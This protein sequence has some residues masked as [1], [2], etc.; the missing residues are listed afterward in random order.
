MTSPGHWR[1]GVYQRLISFHG[2]DFFP[3]NHEQRVVAQIEQCFCV[4][5]QIVFSHDHCMFLVLCCALHRWIITVC[6]LY[7]ELVN[8]ERI[9]IDTLVVNITSECQPT[10]Q[11]LNG[12][13]LTLALVVFATRDYSFA[14]LTRT[15]QLPTPYAYVAPI[16]MPPSRNLT[17]REHCTLG[18]P[19]P[20]TIYQWCT[21]DHCSTA[22]CLSTRSVVHSSI[23]WQP[24]CLYPVS[25]ADGEL[26]NL[27]TS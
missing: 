25:H 17:S 18:H 11:L 20:T 2:V 19:W 9:G 5:F 26:T 6:Y 14:C 22:I 8:L 7:S 4:H 24:C 3:W 15:S 27:S 21:I 16:P 1:E 10:S 13:W 12:V 23:A